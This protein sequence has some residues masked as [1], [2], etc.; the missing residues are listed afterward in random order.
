MA[1]YSFSVLIVNYHGREDTIKCVK[2]VLLA[3]EMADIS[4]KILVVDNSNDDFKFSEQSVHVQRTGHNIG[5]S[6]AWYIGFYSEVVQSCDYVI[7]LNNDA[8]LHQNFFLEINKGID[9]WGSDCAFGPRIC[10]E[11]NHDLIWSRGG[12]IKR[13]A[14][15]VKHFGES[16]PADQVERRD[17][18]TGH[19]SGCCMIL[20]T[21]HLN[22]IGGPDTNFFFRGEEWDINYRLLK[23]GVSLV[24]LDH[25]EVFHEINGSHS[26]FDPGMLYF[27]YRAK[28]L[29]AKKILP[30]WYFPIWYL[31]GLT[32]SA[33]VAPRRFAQVSG[34]EVSIIRKALMSAFLIGLKENKILPLS[35]K[36]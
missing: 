23:A 10:Y 18:E 33:T 1:L 16:L 25:A 2:S 31:A 29:F 32:F 3:A 6:G 36:L 17:F 26:R 4:V 34:G 14:V 19:I 24:I 28:V 13:F 11:N 35:H 22:T 12:Y 30:W 27:A 5:L 8:I 9:K 7:F 15:S 20:R 21:E